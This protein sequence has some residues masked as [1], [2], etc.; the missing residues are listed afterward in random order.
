[1][2][3]SRRLWGIGLLGGAVLTGCASGAEGNAPDDGVNRPAVSQASLQKT[4]EVSGRVIVKFRD[5]DGL[6]RSLSREALAARQL[7]NRTRIQGTGGR[8]VHDLGRINAVA[9]ELSAAQV[10]A[11]KGDPN[12]AYVELDP[13]T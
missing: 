10:A 1:M 3:L 12:V 11:L 8:V 6:R 4:K 9:A 2:K 5:Q 13:R 7:Q